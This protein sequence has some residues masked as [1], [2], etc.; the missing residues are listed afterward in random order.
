MEVERLSKLITEG[1]NKNTANIDR[2]NTYDMI[3]MINEEDKKVA[4][5]VEKAKEDIAKAVDVVSER[6]LKGGRLIYIGAGTSGRLGIIDASECPPT[7]GVDHDLIQGVIAGGNSAIFKAVEGA[8]DSEKLGKK[9][10]MDL[11]IRKEDV[12]CGIAASG[13]T[14]YVIGGMKYGKEIGAAIISITMNTES[15]MTRIADVG[16]SVVVGPEVIMGSTRMKSGTAQKMILNMIST[17]TMIKLGKVYENL[18]VDLKAS[19][20]KLIAR[21][22]RILMLAT[23][24]SLEEAEKLLKETDYDI[25]LSIVISKTCLHKEVCKTLL[26]N[27]RGYVQKAIEEGNKFRERK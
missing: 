24:I 8:E 4:F 20:D 19:N 10:L 23:G 5:A 2:V 21:A 17:G 14:P 16:I 26:Q 6:L 25:K 3:T 12:I 11:N 7:F 13:R 15:E 18:M 9:D 27:N 22:K 1:I